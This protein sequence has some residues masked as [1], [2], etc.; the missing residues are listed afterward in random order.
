MTRRFVAKAL[1]WM[2]L[3]CAAFYYPYA[4][5]SWPSRALEQYLAAI[6]RASGWLISLFG[7]EVLV[8]G[9]SI[10]GAFPL[11][12]VKAC[13]ALDAQALFAAAALAFPASLPRKLLGLGLGIALLTL[14]NL[15]RIACL[16]WIGL[17]APDYFDAV[18]EEWLPAIL[19]LVACLS[20]AAWARWVVQHGDRDALAA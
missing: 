16:Y 12:I 14:L 2:L 18:H 15:V 7:A 5:D 11:Q 6:A 13:S 17:R 20:F 8:T 10:G 4:P 9:T 3:L 19:V 1:V